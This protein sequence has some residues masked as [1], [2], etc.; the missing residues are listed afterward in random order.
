MRAAIDEAER[1]EHAPLLARCWTY[2]TMLHR[3]RQRTD[4]VE[5][6]ARKALKVAMA[7]QMAD[8]AAAA[9][10]NLGWVAWKEGRMAEAETLCQSALARWAPLSLVFPFQWMARWP[11]LAMALGRGELGAAL[12]HGRALLELRQQRLPPRT[13][14]ALEQEQLHQALGFASSDGHL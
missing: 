6:L 12:A 9:E 11:L 8:Y 7:C 13:H 10:A 4:T 2:L 14:E 3:Q 5:R 1:L